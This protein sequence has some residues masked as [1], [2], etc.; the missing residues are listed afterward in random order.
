M[1]IVLLVQENDCSQLNYPPDAHGE[2][3][4]PLA[5]IQ[6]PLLA[7]VGAAWARGRISTFS[8]AIC[9]QI[10]HSGLSLVFLDVR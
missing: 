1:E 7:Y 10:G 8:A 9:A 2:P 4:H 6:P 3:S 5:V